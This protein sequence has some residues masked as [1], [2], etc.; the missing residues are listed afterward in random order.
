MVVVHKPDGRDRLCGDF[1]TSSN[2]FIDSPVTAG[3]EVED[4]LAKLA[5]NKVLSKVDVKDAYLKIRLDESSQLLTVISTPLGL[6]KYKFLPFVVKSAPHIFQ[7]RIRKVLYRL[8]SVFYHLDDVFIAATSQNKHDATL[9]E[10]KR[11]LVEVEL[12]MNETK[13]YNDLQSK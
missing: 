8:P 1:E 11:R 7:T 4:T 3:L 13:S 2:P 9:T 5:G 10:L 6:F 12:P